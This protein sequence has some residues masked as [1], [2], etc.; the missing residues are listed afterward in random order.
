M[1]L[2][3]GS[4]FLN[5]S[6]PQCSHS[7]MAVSHLYARGHSGCGNCRQALPSQSSQKVKKSLGMNI[8]GHVSGWVPRSPRYHEGGSGV[9]VKLP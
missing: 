5:F 1:Q 2:D 9:C 4:F 7:V 3:A 6:F 8:L